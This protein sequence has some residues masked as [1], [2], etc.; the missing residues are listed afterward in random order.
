MSQPFDEFLLDP[1]YSLPKNIGPRR[2][3]KFVA[4]NDNKKEHSSNRAFSF[5]LERHR[6]EQYFD[7]VFSFN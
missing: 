7:H 1:N 6:K 4:H 5:P 3:P 2:L